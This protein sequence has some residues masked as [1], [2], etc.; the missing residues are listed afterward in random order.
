M[1]R[2]TAW[3][4]LPAGQQQAWLPDSPLL[5]LCESLVSFSPGRLGVA[6]HLHGLGPAF[7]QA[8]GVKM[9]YKELILQYADSLKTDLTWASKTHINMLTML[10]AENKAAAASICATIER[11]VLS[12]PSSGKLP[13]LYLVDSI[14]KNV[15]EPYISLF[16][17]NLIQV[18]FDVWQQREVHSQLLKLLATWEGI[19][20]PQ[21]LT[22]LK[23]RVAQD[24]PSQASGNA[25]Q[26]GQAQ[27]SHWGQRMAN[28]QQPISSTNTSIPSTSGRNGYYAASHVTGRL[29]SAS[30]QHPQQ[31]QDSFQ[32]GYAAAQVQPSQRQWQSHQAAQQASS[33]QYSQQQ[34]L[35]LPNLL[36][37]LLSSGLLTVPPSV[38]IAPPGLSAAPAVFYT[39]PSSRAATPEAVDPEDCKFV[40][41]RLKVLSWPLVTALANLRMFS[42]AGVIDR[43]S[44]ACVGVA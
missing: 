16:C 14:L 43:L 20:P 36:S 35:V 4:S 27:S 44:C 30:Y 31:R 28:D 22:V 34:P 40:P 1:L 12:A 38:A 41:S 24:V 15:K 11:H 17:R 6:V 5:V 37:S 10:A 25:L 21:L 26:S 29:M 13:T 19:F 23:Q 32:S 33:V 8:L 7:L 2:S 3:T 9:D 39:H 18:F 42:A